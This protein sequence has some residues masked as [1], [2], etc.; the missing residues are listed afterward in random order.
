MNNKQLHKLIGLPQFESISEL[1]DLMHISDSKII[2]I[3]RNSRPFYRRFTIP[4]KNGDLRQIYQPNKDVKAI[5]TWILRNIFD[6]LNPSMYATAYRKKYSIIDNVRFHQKQKYFLCLDIEDFFP[7]IS[8]AN[9]KYFFISIGYSQNM[10]DVLSRLCACDN[11]LPQ[12]G[13][14]S[15]ALSNFICYKLDRRIAGFSGKKRI[16]F[17]RYADDITLSSNNRK[18]LNYSYAIFKKII[19]NEGFQLNTNKTRFT[20]PGRSIKITGLVKNNSAPTFSIGK[21]RKNHMRYVFFNFI[22]NSRVVDEKYPTLESAYGW[23]SFV[24]SIDLLSFEY[25]TRYIDRLISKKN[26]TTAST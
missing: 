22:I 16:T 13:I 8:I 4:K 7:S 25:I 24:K 5:Q 2:S 14:T 9:I 6:L 20:G 21:K 10:A 19:V 26:L 12:G 15:P 3:V 18:V 23:L 17:T 11:K 1:A